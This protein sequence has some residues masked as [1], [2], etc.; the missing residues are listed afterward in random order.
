MNGYRGQFE[1]ECSYVEYDVW[2]GVWPIS[3]ID[4]MIVSLIRIK[5]EFIVSID[6]DPNEQFVVINHKY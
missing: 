5:L 6:C 1:I 4:D 2:S 3:I